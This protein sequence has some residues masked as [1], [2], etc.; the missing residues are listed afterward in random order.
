MAVSTKV[1]SHAYEEVRNDTRHHHQKAAAALVL[2]FRLVQ[3]TFLRALT[4]RYCTDFVVCM[5]WSFRAAAVVV[6]RATSPLDNRRVERGP[7][8]TAAAPTAR[9]CI[10]TTGASSWASR[11]TSSKTYAYIEYR[12]RATKKDPAMFGIAAGI[13]CWGTHRATSVR[14]GPARVL[15]GCPLP[16]SHNKLTPYRLKTTHTRPC[17][18]SSLRSIASRRT[19]Q[20]SYSFSTSACLSSAARDPDVPVTSRLK[21]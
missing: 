5:R 14:T 1:F 8:T 13:R 12:I 6:G 10:S 7:T 18:S 15:I 20:P 11:R 16:A 17:H 21:S 19:L 9:A 4:R 3:D 2:L